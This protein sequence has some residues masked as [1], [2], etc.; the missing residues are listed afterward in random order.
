[1]QRSLQRRDAPCWVRVRHWLPGACCRLR[2]R[3]LLVPRWCLAIGSWCVLYTLFSQSPSLFTC[4]SSLLH[5]VNQTKL[6]SQRFWQVK[7]TKAVLCCLLL[8]LSLSSSSA[9]TGM[10][11]LLLLNFVKKLIVA[12]F[13]K[14]VSHMQVKL[15]LDPG[16][17]LLDIGFTEADPNHG[18]HSPSILWG[19]YMQA[20][21]V[22]GGVSMETVCQAPDSGRNFQLALE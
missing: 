22:E 17:V 7:D 10:S 9:A 6:Q 16:V 18:A 14:T 13:I 15:P 4:G 12:W 20:N 2:R 8:A 11:P 19:K 1:M 5:T 3:S 21:H